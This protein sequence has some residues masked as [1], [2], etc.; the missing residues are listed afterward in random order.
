MRFD[1][2]LSFCEPQEKKERQY[3]V[4]FE[5]I[6]LRSSENII[7]LGGFG[8]STIKCRIVVSFSQLDATLGGQ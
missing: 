3:K 8:H 6:R 5:G 7:L 4:F 2:L 1:T